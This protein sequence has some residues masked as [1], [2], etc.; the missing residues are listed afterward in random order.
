[1]QYTIIQLMRILILNWR[2]LR[3]PLAGGA[4]VA[5]FEHAKRW[6]KN[7]NAEV[8]WLSP[9]YDKT[10][11][12]ES[13]EGVNFKY[14]GLPLTRKLS[15]LIFTY[16]L[17]FFL[18]IYNYFRFYRNRIDVVIDQVHGLPYL[19]PLYVKEKIVVYIHEIAGD[20]WNQMYV[21]PINIIGRTLEKLVFIP[22]RN[23][24]FIAVSE[25][26]KSD[27]VKIGIPK[28]NIEIVYNGV[29]VPIIDS[30][31]KKEDIFT[32]IYLNRLVKMKGI[33][34]AIDIV[35][36]VKKELPNMHFWIVGKG[37]DDYVDYLNQKV[38]SLDLESNTKFFGYVDEETKIDLLT[39][40]HVLINT[41]YKEGWGL[42]NLE[43]NARG[44][45]V[46]GFDVNG[47][48][49]SISDGIS[50]YICKSSSNKDF[51]ELV[52]KIYN[53]NTL[54]V[55]SIEFAKKFDWNKQSKIYYD[56]LLLICLNH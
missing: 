23:T 55:S 24:K 33:E 27:L 53:S 34:R 22:Y 39:R 5:T 8:T 51:A 6:V 18:V 10:I 52:L 9:V 26:T 37:E 19:T 45:P 3:D 12:S 47:N 46:V 43:A 1:M 4:E 36:E 49:E 30:P 15:T 7:H 28:E 11:K 42:V 44:T 54:Q 40:A 2:S 48:S 32:I 20:I 31:V 25:S 35:S 38:K 29:N 50:G 21:F 41:S 17:F 56:K 14:I 16:P 13:I